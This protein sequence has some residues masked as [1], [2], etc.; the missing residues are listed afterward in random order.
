MIDRAPVRSPIHLVE[1]LHEL[2]G[3]DNLLEEKGLGWVIEHSHRTVGWV[4]GVL[5][6]GL[7]AGLARWEHRRW[8]RWAG[9]VAFL[10][11]TAQGI[12]GMLRVELDQRLSPDVGR[13][14]ALLH[15][16]S[17]QL[18]FALLVSIALWTSPAWHQLRLERAANETPVRRLSL[19]LVAVMYLQI[20]FGAVMR[21]K[22]LALAT[23]AHVLLAFAVVAVA[24]WLG[25]RLLQTRTG[26]GAGRRGVWL[27]GGLLALQV[28]LG[29]ETLVSKFSVSWG[30]TL[31][32]IE[33]VARAPE[34][35]RSIHFLVGALTF[36]TAVCLALL[37]HRHFAW[38]QR[39]VIAQSP[40]RQLESAL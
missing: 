4:V 30:Y 20:V 3:L 12:L 22:E 31:E 21:H 35:I 16:S 11:V 28:A 18:V 17:A 37:A 9:L 40:Q 34:L 33:P 7:A 6:I 36:S 13:T 2:G 15:G 38:I 10:G 8:L 24:T 1:V 5:V 32:R 26:G 14:I 29:L 19:W 23:R 39:P 25:L 27:L